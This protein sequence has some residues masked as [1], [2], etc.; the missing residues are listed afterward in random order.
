MLRAVRRRFG[1]FSQSCLR[2]ASLGCN[3]ENVIKIAIVLTLTI[4]ATWHKAL[5]LNQGR[6]VEM[7]GI[8]LDERLR[9]ESSVGM[10]RV[11]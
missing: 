6:L 3:T 5:K 4:F 10:Y 1:P 8:R 7:G 9:F 2:D 11:G